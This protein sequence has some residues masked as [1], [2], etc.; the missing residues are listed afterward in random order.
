MDDDMTGWSDLQYIRM[1]SV[2]VAW[3]GEIRLTFFTL[4]TVRTPCRLQ[5]WTHYSRLVV[6]LGMFAVIVLGTTRMVR[7][8]T[9]RTGH[10]KAG[11]LRWREGGGVGTNS[12]VL[13]CSYL[14]YVGGRLLKGRCRQRSEEVSEAP[15]GGSNSEG[16]DVRNSDTSRVRDQ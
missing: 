11:F 3:K 10:T 9:G 1:P 14:D 16:R 5:A 7:A 2:W 4:W 6:C 13:C 12:A 15:V 8:C